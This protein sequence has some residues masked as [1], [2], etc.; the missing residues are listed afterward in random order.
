[1]SQPAD[2]P[3]RCRVLVADDHPLMLEAICELLARAPDLEVVAAVRDG[4]AAV[5]QALAL[6]PDVALLDVRMPGGAGTDA[7]QAIK[8]A[9][10]ATHVM[11]MS[12]SDERSVVAEALAK[13]CSGYLL[14]GG[15]VSDIAGA[16]R[17]V[18]AGAIYLSPELR[19]D[20]A[21]PSAR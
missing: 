9:L 16:I 6:R 5:A 7:A 2:R 18:M 15:A 11:C 10:P 13:G 1:M 20:G 3:T 14:K 12:I 8:Q 19:G 21:A 4:H 17:A